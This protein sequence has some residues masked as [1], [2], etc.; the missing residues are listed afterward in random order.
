[1]SSFEAMFKKNAYVHWYTAEGMD[2]SE[3]REAVS[4]VNDL[5]SEYQ[6]YE[7]WGIGGE[8]SEADDM[9]DFCKAANSSI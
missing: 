5:I 7:N 9:V 6:Q 1:M 4:N 3:F 2:Q 8:D